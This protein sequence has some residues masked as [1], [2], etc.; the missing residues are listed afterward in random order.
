MRYH[1]TGRKGNTNKLDT[2]VHVYNHEQKDHVAPSQA[3]WKNE[4][5]WKDKLYLESVAEKTDLCMALALLRF[6]K[7]SKT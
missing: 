1:L 4:R 7:V 5:T 6:P 3:L 2:N